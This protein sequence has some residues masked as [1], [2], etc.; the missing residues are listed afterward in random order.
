[1]SKEDEESHLMKSSIKSDFSE[2]KI[3]KGT[4]TEPHSIENNDLK[5]S[6][7]RG[8][9]LPRIAKSI[10]YEKPLDSARLGSE[11]NN[12]S[13]EKESIKK[14]INQDNSLNLRGKLWKILC[15]TDV[16]IVELLEEY[17][18]NIDKVGKE[19]K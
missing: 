16:I 8:T 14:S 19:F 15:K 12:L 4:I 2:I 5:N 3:Q 6:D 7:I 11:P 17:N 10:A 1:V 18:H 9:D 13:T